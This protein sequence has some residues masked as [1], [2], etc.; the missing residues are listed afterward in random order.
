MTERKCDTEQELATDIIRACE[1]ATIDVLARHSI[2][3]VFDEMTGDAISDF[4]SEAAD[5]VIEV[6]REENRDID[7]EDLFCHICG[8]TRGD[9]QVEDTT[10]NSM[11][12]CLMC[13]NRDNTE[14]E[15]TE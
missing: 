15:V 9:I 6:I 14:K 3:L 13:G 8:T 7:R 1:K 4:Y 10:Y 12:V 5:T 2:E 11:P